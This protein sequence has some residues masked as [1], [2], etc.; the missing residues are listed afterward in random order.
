[1]RLKKESHLKKITPSVLLSSLSYI[2]DLKQ[3]SR[4]T[5]LTLPYFFP[6]QK[7][8]EPSYDAPGFIKRE[9]THF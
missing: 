8:P 5:P 7:E 6:I 3:G 9:D 1:M 4:E 2:Q